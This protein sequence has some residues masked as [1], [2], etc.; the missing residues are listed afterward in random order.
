MERKDLI[1][2]EDLVKV[3]GSG[4][5]QVH[6]LRGLN[7]TVE[8]GEFISI[9]GPSGSG[10][11]TLLNIISGVEKP[12]AGTAQINGKYIAD[13]SS[14]ELDNYRLTTIGY[15]FQSYNL[16]PSLN[17]LDNIQL[18]I[19]AAD[20]EAS[21]AKERANEL[22]E[23]LNLKDRATHRP[24]ELSG[25]EQQRVAIAVALANEPK[26]ILADEPTGNIDSVAA[27]S[28]MKYLRSIVDEFKITLIL[29]THDD[30]VARSADWIYL[31]QDGQIHSRVEPTAATTHEVSCSSYLENR[32]EEIK[33]E[34]RALDSRIGAGTIEG[35]SYAEAR[36][37]LLE[38]KHVLQNELMKLGKLSH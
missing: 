8:E 25:G 22:L 38:A 16:I 32:V 24:H 14:E 28:L 33:G 37:T 2:L 3:W 17:A 7:L 23:L 21:F 20:K 36:A 11:T 30:A 29:V 4:S 13:M 18:P 12:T 6:A 34:L 1:K 35:A 10:K 31:I 27:T 26:I 19:L 5:T 15:I 9:M